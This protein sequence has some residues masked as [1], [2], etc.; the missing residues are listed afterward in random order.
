MLLLP[1]LFP[2]LALATEAV[3]IEGETS[4]VASTFNQHNWYSDVD[5]TLLSPG[6][7]ETGATGGWAAH[8]ANDASPVE[9]TWAFE[10]DEGGPY[11]VWA[12]V[13]TYRVDM[14]A[15][16]DAD[17]PVDVDPDAL[18]RE[19]INLVYPTLDVRYLTWVKV[20]TFDLA[21]GAHTL[22]FGL[23]SDPDWGGSQTYGGVDAFVV[24]NVPRWAPTGAV[25]PEVDGE[26]PGTA[27]AWF[28]FLPKDEGVAFDSAMDR[29]ALLERPAGA[30]GRVVRDGADLALADGTPIKLWG[31]NAGDI[32]ATPEL[33]EQQSRFWARQGINVVRLHSV[34]SWL[35]SAR[36]T[37]GSPAFD[38]ERLDALDHWFAT[39]AEQGIYTTWSVFYPFVLADSDD[40]PAELRA[41][42]DSTSGGR[43][44]SG[45]ATFR[46]EIQDAE[47]RW[48]AALLA[49]ANPY[50][51]RTYAADPALAVIELRNEDSVFWHAPLNE[52]RDGT[53][54]LHA[55]ELKAAWAEWLRGRY[56][57]DAALLA[58]WGPEWGGSRPDD[59][60]DNPAMEIY[61]AW[62]FGADGPAL[63]GS[64]KVRMGDFVRFLAET[65]REGYLRR[66][67]AMRDA[68][69]DGLVVSTAWMSGG[70]AAH[71]ANAWTD[72]ALDM[73]DRHAYMGGGEG[74]WRV[75]AGTVDPYT[76]FD[77]PGEGLLAMNAS[78]VEDMPFSSSE[79]GMPNPG[80]FAAEGAPLVAFYGLGL[81]G[82]DASYQFSTN[83]FTWMGGW[84]ENYAYVSE[85]P[86]VMGLFPALATA[87]HEGHVAEGELAAAQRLSLD[88][89]MSGVDARVHPPAGEGFGGGDSL[90]VPAAVNLLG[91]VTHAVGDGAPE[92]VDWGALD[93]VIESLGGQLAW[94][95]PGRFATVRSDRTQGIVGFGGGRTHALPDVT[96]QLDT[97]YGVLLFTALDGRPLSES[98]RVLIT[99][100]ARER[101]S[102]AAYSD[103]DTQLLSVGGPPLLM[104]P[105]VAQVTL[106][107]VVSVKALD[108]DGWP[109]VDVPVEAGSFTLDGRWRTNWYLAERPAP[110]DTGDTG[111]DAKDE[112]CGCAA[113]GTDGAS[114]LMLVAGLAAVGRRRRRGKRTANAAR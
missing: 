4:P 55:A 31:V 82:W 87:V 49:H 88:A 103:D 17:A 44:A 2:S 83:S 16:I 69:Y 26:A 91:R 51:G 68:G 50:T 47:S 92:A 27:N 76:H 71:L 102:G 109:R 72:T 8:F 1:L 3:W 77:H 80:P 23:E 84:P 85:T 15:Q 38:A 43:S 12:R 13:G 11:T 64:E 52:L 111:G 98:A 53:Y 36:N 90:A 25:R 61:G 104:E 37:D 21:A 32:P 108:V 6:N 101:A 89:V 73:V 14:W 18:G 46:P 66:A 70:D 42:L 22:T 19:T 114:A 39:L 78:Q 28:P 30:R 40:Y 35:G 10:L 79:W 20:G 57:D 94:D 24:T 100:V 5:D 7:P 113:G 34:Q 48:L 99:A 105:V 59:S 96:V 29:S 106:P 107:G 97:G 67:Q 74:V 110:D 45:M 41:E 60:L 62:E 95:V 75:I 9:A 63:N 65:Q 86:H 58:A 93:G 56:A 112:G 54:P 33:R 81:Q